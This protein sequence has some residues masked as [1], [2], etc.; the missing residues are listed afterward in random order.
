V[1]GSVVVVEVEEEEE[2]AHLGQDK[3]LYS[4]VGYAMVFER[5]STD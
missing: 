2:V 5:F 1:V 4:M 3:R